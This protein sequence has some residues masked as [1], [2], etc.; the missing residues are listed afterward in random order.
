MEFNLQQY[1]ETMRGE[2]RDDHALLVMKIEEV[3]DTV[4]T[5]ET[6]ITVVENTRKLL[7]WLG[8]A[9][10]VAALPVLYDIVSNHLLATP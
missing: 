7:L 1:L 10:V 3:K 2:Q 8:G 5:H 6:R 4:G 9:A